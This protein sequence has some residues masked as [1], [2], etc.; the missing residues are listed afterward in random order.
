MLIT[1]IFISADSLITII[2]IISACWQSISNT[3]VCE[4]QTSL[5]IKWWLLQFTPL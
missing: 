2:I 4:L 5:A 3:E 1:I